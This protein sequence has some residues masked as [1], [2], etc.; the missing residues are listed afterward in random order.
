[1]NVSPLPIFH[2]DFRVFQ[3]GTPELGDTTYV[4]ESGG[5]VIAIDPQRDLDR[6][7]PVLHKV[8]GR[9]VAVFETHV[10]NDYVSG[11]P[12]LARATGAPYLVPANAGVTVADGERADGAEI[13]VGRVRLRALFTPGHTP[14]HMSYEIVAGDGVAGVFTGG[15]VLVGA[16]GR[17][18]LLGPELAEE[19]TR[20]QYRS[21]Q[22]IGKLLDSTVLGPTHGSGSFCSS[23]GVGG[24]SW[25]TVERER[26]ANPAFLAPDEDAFVRHHLS[27]RLDFPN[28]YQNMA[29]INRSG[30]TAWIPAEP[31]RLTL[32][33]L[34]EAMRSSVVAVDG[35]DAVAFAS[36]HLT[37]SVN[38]PLDN[39]FATYLGWVFPF[40]T[41][42]AFVGLA[43]DEAKAAARQCAR[44][45]IDG[46]V[47]AAYDALVEWQHTEPLAAYGVTDAIGLRDAVARGATVLDVRQRME[48]ASGHVPGS[49]NVP[50][51]ELRER[52]ADVPAGPVFVHCLSGIRAGTAA[53]LLAAAGYDV[54]LVRDGFE[55]WSAGRFDVAWEEAA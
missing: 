10:H 28:Y 49:L 52:L 2:S 3:L 24:E 32:Q 15:S 14:H 8:G 50:V 40:G 34:L 30:A 22:R 53:S 41:R 5:E 21:A 54:V 16:C 23:N 36:G 55:A 4:L 13:S 1:M 26:R 17:T 25:T 42:F 48:W 33:A 39:S 37:G 44:I 51:T 20:W 27:G 12:A 18:D 38:V 7:D 31:P 43:P 47:G 35:R 19:L 45:G 46:I 11:G 29:G 9:V 6:L